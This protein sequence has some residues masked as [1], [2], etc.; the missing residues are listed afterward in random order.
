MISE[1][2][3]ASKEQSVGIEQLTTVMNDME[4]MVQNNAS[5][6]EESASAAEELSAQS[7]ELTMVVGSLLDMIEDKK[8]Q[9]KADS[10][11]YQRFSNQNQSRKKVSQSIYNQYRKPALSNVNSDDILELDTDL[12]GF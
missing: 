8:Q 10:T 2:S 12:S 1:I 7:D 9:S 6:S 5:A 4:Q 3:T 11:S